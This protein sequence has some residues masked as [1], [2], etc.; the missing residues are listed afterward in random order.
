MIVRNVKSRSGSN[1]TFTVELGYTPLL[2][3][4][5]VMVEIS[6][7]NLVPPP[8]RSGGAREFR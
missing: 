6:A 4:L 8:F 3:V 2:E 7:S 1:F 5:E